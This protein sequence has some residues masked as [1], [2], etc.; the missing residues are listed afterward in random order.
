[1]Q[2]EGI[3]SVTSITLPLEEYP[4]AEWWRQRS[5]ILTRVT[6]SEVASLTGLNTRKKQEWQEFVATFRSE[7]GVLRIQG[8]Y[9]AIFDYF[10]IVRLGKEV[11]RFYVY[12]GDGIL[13]VE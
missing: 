10:V 1:M 9:D 5:S 6:P 2:K 3:R 4:L 7:D 11:R 12:G 8:S 13:A